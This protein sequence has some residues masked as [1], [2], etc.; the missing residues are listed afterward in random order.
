MKKIVAVLM[1]LQW[2]LVALVAVLSACIILGTTLYANDCTSEVIEILARKVGNKRYTVADRL[3]SYGTSARNAMSADFKRS[4]IS[5]PPKR[6][7]LVG[8]K[9]EK[10]LELYA[11]DGSRDPVFIKR[12]PIL[13]ASGA[14]GPKLR[15]GDMQVPEG[16]YRIESLNPNILYHLSLRVNYPNEFDR[17]QA[18]K[19]GRTQLGGDIMI[20]GNQVSIGCLAIGDQAIEELFVL[21]ADTGVQ[22][23]T[24]ILAP[25][26]FRDRDLPIAPSMPQWVPTLYENIKRQLLL[27][28]K[29]KMY[30]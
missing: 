23:V 15:E 25:L 26:D 16:I 30:R 7:I 5:Y 18:R 4:E 13:A 1:K 10:I 20:Y 28:E 19:E 11:S 9:T 27:L 22:N 3:L 21:A 8:L 14:V 12:Y 24:V 29:H 17:N 2:R 6:I